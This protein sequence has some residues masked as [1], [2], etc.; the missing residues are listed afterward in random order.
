[1]PI[2]N[3]AA[4]QWFKPEEIHEIEMRALP[5]FFN[6]RSKSKTPEMYYLP[7]FSFL[8]LTADFLLSW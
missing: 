5:E 7:L 2:V 6:G 1:M 3:P 4:A 8:F